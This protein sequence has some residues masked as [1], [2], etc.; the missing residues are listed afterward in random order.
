[1]KKKTTWK[2]LNSKANLTVK[3]EHYGMPAEINAPVFC[4]Y[5]CLDQVQHKFDWTDTIL[6]GRSPKCLVADMACYLKKDQIVKHFVANPTIKAAI[7]NENVDFVAD[8]CCY[9]HC[10]G[11][12]MGNDIQDAMWS[13]FNAIKE[14]VAAKTWHNMLVFVDDVIYNPMLL[15]KFKK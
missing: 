10:A 6:N 8:L 7:R 1:M 13:I 9:A 4:L 11:A 3:I 12:L 5:S 14:H 2:T 15:D